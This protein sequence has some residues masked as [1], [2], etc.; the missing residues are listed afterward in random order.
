[1]VNKLRHILTMEYPKDQNEQT[2]LPANTTDEYH[3]Y[4]VGRNKTD[5]QQNH[6]VRFHL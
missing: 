1:M 2:L 4:R 3:E 6:T 5:T